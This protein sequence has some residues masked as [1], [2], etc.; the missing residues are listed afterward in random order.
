MATA[1][2]Y[3]PPLQPGT[4]I[5]AVTFVN[6]PA[7]STIQPS[8]NL[9]IDVTDDDGVA[10]IQLLIITARFSDIG[11]EE[12]IFRASEFAYSYSNSTQSNITNGLRFVLSRIGGWPST[13]TINVDVVDDG[14]QRT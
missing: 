13:P 4:A 1:V 2:F 10:D 12:V 14:G 6:P 3:S 5:P 9:T 8:Q 7:G 11:A